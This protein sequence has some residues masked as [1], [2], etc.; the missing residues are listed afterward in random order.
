MASRT[1]RRISP[2]EAF[3]ETKGMMRKQRNIQRGKAG[4]T[5]VETLAVLVVITLITMVVATGVPAA[6]RAYVAAVDSSNAQVLLNTAA[7]RLR[8]Q[9]SVANPNSVQ[10]G[11]GDVLITYDSY[12]TGC[13]TQITNGSEEAPGLSV[14]EVVQ[15]SDPFAA[16]TPVTTTALLVSDTATAGLSAKIYVTADKI[17]YARGSGTF[18]VSNLQVNS[19]DAEGHVTKQDT[20]KIGS[21]DVKV[22]AASSGTT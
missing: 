1:R 19:V 3:V 21:M 14:S 18:V 16:A 20:A 17:E 6:Q 11:S 7:M 2:I 12:E 13:T 15:S 10:A 9:L 5:L 4:F 8:D 22:L